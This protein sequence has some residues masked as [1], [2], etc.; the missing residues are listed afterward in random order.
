MLCLFGR[1]IDNILLMMYI[2]NAIQYSNKTALLIATQT[3]RFDIVEY[4]VSEGA[5]VNVKDQVASVHTFI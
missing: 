3:G 5:D 2:F 4:L 1:Y